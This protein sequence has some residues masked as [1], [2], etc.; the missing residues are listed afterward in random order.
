MGSRSYGFDI[1]TLLKDAGAITANAAAQV[2]GSNKIL[3]LGA[4][5]RVDAVVV[6]DVTA[7][8]ISSGDEL[9]Y[10]TA[11]VSSSSSF[12]SDIQNVGTMNFGKSAVRLGGA[13]DSLI[14][15]YELPVCTEQAD[16]MRQYFRLYTTVGGTTPS[17]NYTAFLA[18]LPDNA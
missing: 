15:R 17:I 2:G 12:A 10:I 16:V 13:I 4:N 7:I 6:I 18:P 8:D 1:L 14:G 3:D 9:Y 5:T 11:Q